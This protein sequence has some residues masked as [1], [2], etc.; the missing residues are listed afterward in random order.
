MTPPRDPAALAPCPFCGSSNVAQGAARDQI[1]VWCF[2]G[3]RGPDVP[4]PENCDPLPP[5][6]ECHALWNTR[7]EIA[8]ALRSLSASTPSPTDGQEEMVV[9]AAVDYAR[10]KS[11][12]Q[13]QRGLM[14]DAFMAGADYQ[15]TAAPPGAL[16]LIQDRR[17]KSNSLVTAYMQVHPKEER[18]K[19]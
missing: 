19:K 5:I 11:N 9:A 7:T 2:C 14:R 10:L 12:S 15:R 8:D 3:A 4:F 1:S 13:L 16:V 17:G 18:R 6:R